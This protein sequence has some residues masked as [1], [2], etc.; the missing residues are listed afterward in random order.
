MTTAGASL[1]RGSSRPGL[2]PRASDRRALARE[3]QAPVAPLRRY[4]REA[5]PWRAS[6]VIRSVAISTAGLIVLMG[7]YYGSSRQVLF[8]D[9]TGW[10]LGSIGASLLSALG[11]VTF[12]TTGFRE[13][14][15]GVREVTDDLAELAQDLEPSEQVGDAVQTTGTTLVVVEGFATVH[16]PS[17]LLAAG[18]AVR[19]VEGA[20]S[21]GSSCG[22][23]SP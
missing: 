2:A 18:K 15:R 12:L 3:Q 7:C 8:V 19:P 20:G 21:A 13:I 17:C 10:I 16:R 14:R 5:S 11:M 1:D 6:D 4:C 23:C 22:V 9:Q